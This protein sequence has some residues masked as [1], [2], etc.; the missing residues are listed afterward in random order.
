MKNWTPVDVIVFVLAITVTA[1]LLISTTKPLFGGEDVEV[2]ENT[3]KLVAGIL[4][5]LV[6]VVSVYVGARVQK[7]LDENRNSRSN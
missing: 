3:A 1:V 5:S 4:G 7:N 6:S 2:S